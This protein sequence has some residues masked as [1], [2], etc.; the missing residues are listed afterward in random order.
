MVL[1]VWKGACA[2]LL[3]VVLLQFYLIAY[4]PAVPHVPAFNDQRPA[5]ES[6]SA[7]TN[8]DASSPKTPVPHAPA[9][10]WRYTPERDHH[11][12][13]L[14]TA[15][16][17]I[18]F[19]DL[20]YEIDRAAKYW[21]KKHH[22][23]TKQ[24]VD[25]FN[26]RKDAA[27]QALI[28]NNQL[29]ILRTKATWQQNGYKKRAL[30]M[31]AQINRALLGASAAGETVPNIE[32]AAVVDD[33]SLIPSGNNITYTA[34]AFTRHIP[35]HGEDKLWIIPDFNFYASPPRT[36]SFIEQQRRASVHDLH[37]MDKIPKA[38]WRGVK[39]TNEDIRGPLLDV[40]NGKDWADV[41]EVNWEYP[42]NTMRMEDMCKYMFTIHTEGRSWSGRLKFLLNC[43]SVPIVH[44]LDWAAEFYHLLQADG[45]GQNYV[46]VKRNFSDLEKKIKY[47]IDNPKEAQRIA[48]NAVRTFRSRYTSP[49]AE[50]CYWR[51]LF[52]RYSE[53]SFT[54]EPF[55]TIT[56]QSAG[57]EIEDQQLRGITYEEM[58]LWAGEKNYPDENSDDEET[59]GKAEL[60][61]EHKPESEDE[62]NN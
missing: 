46:P 32:F 18:A 5:P 9:Q 60:N 20:Y 25:I 16:C 52:R 42:N 6:K 37:V 62:D 1:N 50:S 26:W 33:M 23:I 35:D 49:A 12:I 54:P 38:V 53:V 58:L 36:T 48:D 44:K 31:M 8:N 40:T 61:V 4:K 19:P 7:P 15:Q 21:E 29:R 10:A 3:V 17:D 13:G 11:N 56:R 24:D 45:P 55:E 47:Y 39:W 51:R 22:N 27:V 34:W 57:V 14:T 43:D 28:V 59:A 30:P 2:F 41:E